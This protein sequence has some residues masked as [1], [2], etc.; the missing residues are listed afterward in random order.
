[1]RR[2]NNNMNTITLR[3]K[4]GTFVEKFAT[5]DN[6]LEAVGQKNSGDLMGYKTRMG[7]KF[8]SGSHSA[9]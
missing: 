5:I 2:G 1:M 3:T 7:P 8:A 9:C 6:S 4:K